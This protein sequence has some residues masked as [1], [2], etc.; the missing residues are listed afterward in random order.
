MKKTCEICY[1]LYEPHLRKQ[2]ELRVHSSDSI[3]TRRYNVETERKDETRY[4]L[5]PT[6]AREIFDF[7]DKLKGEAHVE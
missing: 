4:L 1:R 3:V 7:I 5:C 2:G 6:C